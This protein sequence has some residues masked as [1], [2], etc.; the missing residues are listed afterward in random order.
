[1]GANLVEFK[2]FLECCVDFIAHLEANDSPI[3]DFSIGSPA[4]TEMEAHCDGLAMNWYALR[5]LERAA[6][7]ATATGD[8]LD[9]HAYTFGGMTRRPSMHSAGILRFARTET[10]A[11]LEVPVGTV[12]STNTGLQFITIEAANFAI[13][14]SAADAA[15]ISTSN[16]IS[17]NVGAHRITVVISAVSGIT[18]VDNP[19]PFSGGSD[20]ETNEALRSRIIAAFGVLAHGVPES[21]TTWALAADSLV[22]RASAWGQLRASNSVD[23]YIASIDGVAGSSLVDAVQAYIDPRRPLTSNV[24]VATAVLVD[25]DVTCTVYSDWSK[26]SSELEA[27]V[28]AAIIAYL[29]WRTWDFGGEVTVAGILGAI[30]A[31]DGVHDVTLSVPSANIALEPDELATPGVIAITVVE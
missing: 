12:C 10:G 28:E 22:F 16:G 4:R 11:P 7:A 25:V 29:N 24:L 26:D 8:A 20:E 6:F 27:D 19:I 9:G 21:Y 30:T 2:D 17:S 3:T 31:V 23:I 15:A 14:E 1:V 13:G 5:I 18:G